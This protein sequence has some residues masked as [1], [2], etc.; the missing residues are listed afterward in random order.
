MT[1][2]DPWPAPHPAGPVDGTVRVPGSKSLTNRWLL[3]AALAD[4]PSILHGVLDSRDSRLM[5]QALQTL[6]AQ[7]AWS[8][9]DT[10]Q[11]TPLPHRP[12]VGSVTIDCG[13]AGTVMRFIPA[14]AALATGTVT[15]DGDPEARVRPMGPV[16]RALEQLGVRIDAPE[17]AGPEP[18]T[19]PITVHGTGVVRGGRV[20][21]DASGSSQFV[22]ALLLAAPRFAQGLHLVHTGRSVPSP[23]HIAMTVSVLRQAGVE[24][25]DSVPGTWR[26]APGPVLVRETTVEPDLSNAGPFLAAAVVTGGTVRIPD[27]PAETTQIGDRWRQILPRFGA[28]VSFEPGTE[29]TGT[30]T[31][32]GSID[33]D[34]TPTICGP[35]EIAGT[36]ELAPTVAALCLLADGPSSLTGIG[37]LRGHETDR[38]SALATETSRVGGAVQEGTDRL[39]FAPVSRRS[40]KPEV[41]QT[42]LD[43]RMATFAA[44]VGLAVPEVQIQDVATTAKTMPDFPQMWTALIGTAQPGSGA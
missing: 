43:H 1:P 21:I 9:P 33:T 5:L 28:T 19:L 16:L 6:G 38:L 17:H 26:V 11:I 27:W 41:M 31:V 42:Y 8:G 36:A 22:S 39:D 25:D 12:D 29:S 30:L 2:A 18:T 14:V 37:H 24:V 32:T 40:L 23:E 10:V 34:G 35:G 15:L 20:E 3:L 44:V 4:G 7:V 13:L